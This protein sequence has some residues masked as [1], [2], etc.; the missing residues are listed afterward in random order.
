M[1]KLLL[2]T[3][4]TA[5][6]LALTLNDSAA[7]N[8]IAQKTGNWSDPTVW[9]EDIVHP[10]EVTNDIIYIRNGYTVT[11]NSNVNYSNGISSMVFGATGGNGTLNI[12]S[13]AQLT[14]TGVTDVVRSGNIDNSTGT[15]SMSGGTFSTG[16]LNMGGGSTNDNAT[17]IFN[18]SGGSLTVVGGTIVGNDTVGKTSGSLN[19]TGS[20]AIANGDS[21]TVNQLGT[22]RF[23]LNSTNITTLNYSGAATFAN[24]STLIVDGSSYAGGSTVFTLINAA[25]LSGSLASINDSITGFNPAYTTNLVFDSV[26][27]DVLL[28]VTIPEPST[29]A[30]LGLGVIGLVLAARRRMVKTA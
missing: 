22:I 21:L 1:K 8:A 15:I 3:F 26:N 24:N 14:I 29:W 18:L 9:P 27:G 2:C 6:F 12:Q 7:A 20:A 25:S 16:S 17:A 11:V 23:T 13:G 28:Q 19:V 30:L 10:G 4:S 5:S